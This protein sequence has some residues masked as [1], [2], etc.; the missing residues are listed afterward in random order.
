MKS[1][2]G[3]YREE[4]Y[5]RAETKDLTSIGWDDLKESGSS[6]NNCLSSPLHP[7]F[8]VADVGFLDGWMEFSK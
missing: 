3:Q 6:F 7:I 2:I 8:V 1:K 4:F 5:F